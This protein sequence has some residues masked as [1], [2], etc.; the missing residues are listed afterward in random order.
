M[1][2]KDF[3]ERKLLMVESSGFEPKELNDNLFPFQEFIVRSA[4]K[5]GRYAIFADTGMGKT[6]M[7]LSWAN[8]VNIHTGKP[9][10]ILAPL[11]VSAQT[12]NEG[13][14]FSIKVNKYE[15]PD[16]LK[17]I[18]ISNYEQLDNI[19]CSKFGGIVLDESS[20]LKNF[21]GKYKQKIIDEFLNTPYKL[22]CTATPS[23]NDPMELGNHSEFLNIMSYFE[24]LAMY[25]FHDGGQ[26]AKWKLKGHAEQ[27]FYNWVSQW[28]TMINLPSDI[29][30][31]DDG[32]ILP[33]LNYNEC[34]IETP[35]QE[36]GKLFNDG[37]VNATDYNRTL[38]ITKE[39]RLK[40]TK[41]ILDTL[42]G[43][44]IIW[45]KQNEEADYMCKMLSGYDFR[46]VK[47]SDNP[48]K[49][50]KNLIEFGQGKYRILITKLKIAQ[51]G[52]NFQSCN[53]QIFASLDFSFESTYQG[54]RRSWRFGQ[55]KEVNVFLI[56]TDLMH[57]VYETINIKQRQFTTMQQ[58]MS[59]AI[60]KIYKLKQSNLK[61]EVKTE[62]YHIMQGDCV[63][64]SKTIKDNSIDFSVFSPPFASLY[65]YSDNLEDMG[66][67][68]D[69]KEFF[70]HFEFLITE[71]ERIIKPGRLC[72]VHCMD[73]PIAKGKEGYIGRR[74]FSGDIIRSFQDRGFIFHSRIT[75]WKDPVIEMQRTKSLGLL[76]K[77]LKKDSTLSRTGNPDYLIIFRKHGDNVEP[78][79]NTQIPV[80]L[81]QKY[82][83]PVWMDINQSD[84]LQFR[85]AKENKDE[86]HICPLQL[87]VIERAIVL[88]SNPGDLVYSPFGGIGS[89][90]YQALK[91]DRKAVG[92]EL[93]G[94]YFELMKRNLANI[95]ENKNQLKIC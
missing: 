60:N 83:S 48:D 91:M 79:Q 82:A 75:I 30:F 61:D 78:I 29:G 72:A 41:R 62:D 20:I 22:A 93:K 89:E 45:I 19:D 90:L 74:D 71:L 57:N 25:F 6:I 28:A 69:Q 38:R 15:G 84:T 39:L 44:V 17:G 32:Y 49:K 59:K 3:L 76:Y 24:M 80:D 87:N 47:G 23:P 18:Y 77:Q 12:I 92:C 81:W 35:K 88:W 8:Q 70:I 2:Y 40:E 11:A 27:D 95:M 53:N 21:N 54:I 5:I 16:K 36:N 66:N 73:L 13:V 63:E 14:K 85:T 58:K 65:T 52:L 67:S 10:L 9:V 34:Q 26:T 56:T 86:K 43:Q 51:F 64:L 4:L 46:E 7:Q 42:T 55:T 50:E 31:K 33:N 94:S 68:S 1:E 37:H